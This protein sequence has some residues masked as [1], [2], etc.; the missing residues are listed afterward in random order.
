MKYSLARRITQV[1]GFL[2]G[3]LALILFMTE[4]GSPYFWPLLVPTFI[5]SVVYFIIKYRF[6]RC[7]KCGE[8]LTGKHELCP[9]CRHPMD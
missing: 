6:C 4:K 9:Y 8:M 7:P 3:V 5:L 1:L 2:V